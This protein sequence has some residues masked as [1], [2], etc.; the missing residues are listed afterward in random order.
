MALR[1]RRQR[2]QPAH[3]E[4]RTRVLDAV[5]SVRIDVE[6]GFQVGPPGVAGPAIPE[7]AGHGQE[8]LGSRVPIGV[9]EKSG[10]PEVGTGESVRGSDD[11]PAGRTPD[12]R[13]RVP[14]FLAH[15]K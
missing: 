2:R 15:A 1:P 12:R 3:A 6:P 14:K 11:I 9:V 10:A 13:S 7:L 5:D 4:L 8:L